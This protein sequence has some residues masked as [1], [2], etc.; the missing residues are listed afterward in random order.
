MKGGGMKRKLLASS[1]DINKLI[2]LIKEYFCGS[3]IKL[4]PMNGF[5]SIY[6]NNGEI[7]GFW[8]IYKNGRF[9]FENC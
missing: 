8:V 3:N 5:W 9:R 4:I 6:N 7:V 1:D 2:V